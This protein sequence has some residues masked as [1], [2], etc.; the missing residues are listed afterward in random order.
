[1]FSSHKYDMDLIHIV[2]KDT[3]HLEI[4]EVIPSRDTGMQAPPVMQT[5]ANVASKHG[6]DFET[7]F[8]VKKTPMIEIHDGPYYGVIKSAVTKNVEEA[9]SAIEKVMMGKN[10]YDKNN[11]KESPVD[12]AIKNSYGYKP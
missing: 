9:H 6:Q 5:L 10:I 8:G 4:Q 11:K 3:G 12:L 1:M 7:Y 2:V